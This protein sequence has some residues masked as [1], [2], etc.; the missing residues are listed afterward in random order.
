M[1]FDF[2]NVFKVTRF[3]STFADI[4]GYKLKYM[5]VINTSSHILQSYYIK[6]KNLKNKLSFH[7]KT[8]FSYEYYTL[9]FYIFFGHIKRRPSDDLVRRVLY[10]AYVKKYRG[11]TCLSEK[12]FRFW[13]SILKYIFKTTINRI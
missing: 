1:K 3:H 8:L 7:I 13:S 2:I 12:Y 9:I 11:S 6:F 4:S 5:I 10:P